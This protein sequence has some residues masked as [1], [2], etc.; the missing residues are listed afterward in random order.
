[1][2][3]AASGASFLD[4]LVQVGVCRSFSLDL[5][6]S[7]LLLRRGAR[8][9]AHPTLWVGDSVL[10]GIT[11]QALWCAGSN[12]STLGVRQHAVC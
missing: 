4:Q 8:C 9:P 1:M 3:L 12:G 5:H 7:M 6:F 2:F 11:S 10:L